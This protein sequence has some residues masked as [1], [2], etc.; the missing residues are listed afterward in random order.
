MA[1]HLHDPAGNRNCSSTA[2]LS[3]PDLPFPWKFFG[4]DVERPATALMDLVEAS[5][6]PV[7]NFHGGKQTPTPRGEHPFFLARCL[8]LPFRRKSSQDFRDLALCLPMARSWQGE[9]MKPLEMAARFAAFAWSAV[10]CSG[11]TLEDE[12]CDPR[13]IDPQHPDPSVQRQYPSPS[14]ARGAFRHWRS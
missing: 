13:F 2:C 3:T 10:G 1:N 6:V 9:D 4:Q 14:A 8:R 7:A 12:N 5:L 11:P